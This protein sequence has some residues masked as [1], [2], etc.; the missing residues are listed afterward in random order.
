M[1]DILS[2]ESIP[3]TQ[4]DISVTILITADDNVTP[5]PRLQYAVVQTDRDAAEDEIPSLTAEEDWSSHPKAVAALKSGIPWFICCRDEAGN[6]AVYKCGEAAEGQT[7]LAEEPEP[8]SDM[9]APVIRN[10]YVEAD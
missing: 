2:K 4:G 1:V 5:Y 8:E 10:I 6:T 7:A 9:Q 3:D